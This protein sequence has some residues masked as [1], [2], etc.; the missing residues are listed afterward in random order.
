VAL[1]EDSGVFELTEE[2][3]RRG[4]STI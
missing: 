2:G 3:L 1:N 4:R